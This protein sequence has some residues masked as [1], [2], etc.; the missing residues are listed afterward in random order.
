MGGFIGGTIGGFCGGNSGGIGVSFFDL[1]FVPIKTA[2]SITIPEAR[3]AIAI[4]L[5]LELP[6][7]TAGSGV[8]VSAISSG[9]LV[10]EIK[11]VPTAVANGVAVASMVGA[12]VGPTVADISLENP[13]APQ[14]LL[15]ATTK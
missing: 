13:L 11:L 15:A 8:G 10:G 9:V 4:F 5:I 12:G 1:I 6:L 2:P 14:T 3:S 7:W